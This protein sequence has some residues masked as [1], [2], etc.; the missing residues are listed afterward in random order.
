MSIAVNYTSLYVAFPGASDDVA[1]VKFVAT[2]FFLGKAFEFWDKNTTDGFSTDFQVPFG[3][4]SMTAFTYD[5]SGNQL[6][7]IQI[8]TKLLIIL[9]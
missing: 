7:E 8:I 6:A 4:Y 2:Q 3:I 9:L 1:S 5:G